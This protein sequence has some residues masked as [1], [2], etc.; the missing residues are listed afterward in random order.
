MNDYI[1]Y[2][3]SACDVSSALLKQWG[4]RFSC[5]TFQFDGDTR[6]Y[7]NEE[8][9]IGDFY[10]RLR[11]GQ[12]AKTSAVN[13]STFQTEFEKILREGMDILYIGFASSLSATCQSAQMAAQALQEKYPQRKILVVDTLC[14]SAGH[15]LVLHKTLLQKRSGASIEEA[16]AFARDLSSRVCHW[17]TVDDLAYMK[18]GGRISPATAFVGKA[19]GIKPLIYINAEGKLNSVDKARG[20]KKAME[21]LAAYYGETAKDP[22][23]DV[24]IAHSEYT[25][26]VSMLAELLKEKYRASVSLVT[27][28]GPVVGTHIGPGGM[29]FAYEGKQ[30]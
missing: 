29:I 20:K 9:P 30:R 28:I 4:V 21:A 7:T 26:C 17:L 14:A 18:R 6:E 2:T 16:A 25:D 22:S 15:G 3:D 8:M 24:Y 10:S 11:A 19:L 5:L 12:M 13:V 1:L 27:D 23:G